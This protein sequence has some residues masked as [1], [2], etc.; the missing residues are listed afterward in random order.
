MKWFNLKKDGPPEEDSCVIV[1]FRGRINLEKA[2]YQ[3]KHDEFVL[4]AQTSHHGLLPLD[5]EYY[6][7]L[8][9]PEWPQY[10]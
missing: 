6:V 2:I 9:H 8:N 10:D 5:I 1:S 7:H 4:D 3:K